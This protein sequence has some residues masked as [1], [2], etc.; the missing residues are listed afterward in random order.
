MSG[1]SANNGSHLVEVQPAGRA[2]ALLSVTV[3]EAGGAEQ[4][5]YHV[6]KGRELHLRLVGGNRPDLGILQLGSCYRRPGMSLE[7]RPHG[8]TGP[9]QREN[10]AARPQPPACPLPLR[11]PNSSSPSSRS[12][13]SSG[14]RAISQ[15]SSD[16][17]ARGFSSS[18]PPE[19][20]GLGRSP[21]SF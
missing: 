12:S 16:A 10:A 5:S 19:D 6:L 3:T 20:G 17:S 13:S 14:S 8:H 9:S 7:R 2:Q 1:R 4:W 15:R 21:S 18:S 11:S